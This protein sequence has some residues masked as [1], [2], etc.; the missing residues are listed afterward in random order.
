MLHRHD[1]YQVLVSAF[2]T[3]NI[4]MVLNL[5]IF[6]ECCM[7]N[8]KNWWLLTRGRESIVF[9]G[10]MSFTRFFIFLS[11]EI[12]SK[13]NKLYDFRHQNSSL[14]NQEKLLKMH[15]KLMSIKLVLGD[16]TQLTTRCLCKAIESQSVWD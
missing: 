15:G 1:V 13:H 12:N 7:R 6:L 4:F 2:I 11:F 9:N 14:F 10:L 5:N 16:V 8:F 3:A